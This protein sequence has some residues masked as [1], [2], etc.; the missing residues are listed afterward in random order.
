MRPGKAVSQQRLHYQASSHCGCL[1][2]NPI[3]AFGEQNVL[4]YGFYYYLAKTRPTDQEATATEEIAPYSQLPRGGDTVHWEP[5]GE[6][7]GGRGRGCHEETWLRFL[8]KEWLRQLKY[9]CDWL[10]WLISMSSGYRAILSWLVPGPGVVRDRGWWLEVWEPA[11]QRRCL[12][13]LVWMWRIHGLCTFAIS[14]TWLTLGC[15]YSPTVGQQ[16]LRGQNNSNTGNKDMVDAQ[17]RTYT[18]LTSHQRG[19]A[20]TGWGLLSVVVGVISPALLVGK[21]PWRHLGVPTLSARACGTWVG[22]QQLGSLHW[23]LHS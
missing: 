14:K 9:I 17:D 3:G 15:G 4:K 10:T 22:Q 13:R 16:G 6:A 20:V 5:H 7:P 1:E 21:G 18:S 12:D 11:T 19:E 8:T 23:I 2:R